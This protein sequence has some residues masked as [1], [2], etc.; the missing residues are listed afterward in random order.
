MSFLD[1]LVLFMRLGCATKHARVSL[2]MV[3][4]LHYTQ[5]RNFK[6]VAKLA[7]ILCSTTHGIYS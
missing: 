6:S 3:T 4:N 2:D 5:E 1:E 7:V